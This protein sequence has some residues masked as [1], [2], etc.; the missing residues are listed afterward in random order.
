MRKPFCLPKKSPVRQ[1]G[2]Q[3]EPRHWHHSVEA[4]CPLWGLCLRQVMK[5]QSRCSWT[6]N[7]CSRGGIR[8]KSSGGSMSHA[9]SLLCHSHSGSQSLPTTARPPQLLNVPRTW[10][11]ARSQNSSL[12]EGRFNLAMAK[13]QAIL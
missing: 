8:N 4:D 12:E 11:E 10:N 2:E 5:R 7:P 3:R 9:A 1:G 13:R 6:C